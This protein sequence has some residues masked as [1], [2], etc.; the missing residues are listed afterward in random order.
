V[1]ER[2]HLDCAA[3]GEQGERLGLDVVPCELENDISS[4]RINRSSTVVPATVC[5][6]STVERPRSPPLQSSRRAV[7]DATGLRASGDLVQGSR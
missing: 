2:V 3:T 1:L 7:E 4:V 6:H 5:E